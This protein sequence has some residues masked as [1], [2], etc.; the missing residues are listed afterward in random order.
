[1]AEGKYSYGKYKS[2]DG[3]VHDNICDLCKKDHNMCEEPWTEN[4]KA[5]SKCKYFVRR[6]ND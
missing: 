1:M 4:T 2:S 3:I 6:T 5:V